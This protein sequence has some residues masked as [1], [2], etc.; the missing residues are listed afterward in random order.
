MPKNPLRREYNEK[1]VLRILD[2]PDFRHLT[3]EKAI[4]FVSMIPQ[5]DPQVAMRAL[6]QFPQLKDAALG[7]ARE[8]KEAMVKAL[9][10]D[11]EEFKCVAATIN[12]II[13]ALTK[14]LDEKDLSDEERHYLI[15]QMKELVEM[16]R[17]M[18]R[19]DQGFKLK[20]MGMGAC[21]VG[22]LSV[23]LVAVL[24]ANGKVTFPDFDD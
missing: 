18:K 7:M 20:L 17:R 23:A 22:V 19:D 8:Y 21:V 1:D 15:E 13:D 9:D 6:E 10:S 24:G 4:E 11:T 16:Q 5:M 14:Q 2:I 12:A 3:K